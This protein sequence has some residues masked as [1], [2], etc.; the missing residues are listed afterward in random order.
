MFVYLWLIAIMEIR[1][2]ENRYHM[3]I[4]NINI[5]NNVIISKTDIKMSMEF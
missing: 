3:N 1:N 4:D 2:I 5:L